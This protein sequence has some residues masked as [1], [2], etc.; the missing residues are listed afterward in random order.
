L[1]SS[2]VPDCWV[3]AAVAKMPAPA[4]NAMAHADCSPSFGAGADEK[5]T[6]PSRAAHA[7]HTCPPNASTELAWDVS[8]GYV[9]ARC[10]KGCAKV[11]GIADWLGKLGMSKYVQRFAENGIDVSVSFSLLDKRAIKQF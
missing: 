5:C 10:V 11:Q 9:R 2:A 6:R 1:A 7:G 4:I 8:T 3:G